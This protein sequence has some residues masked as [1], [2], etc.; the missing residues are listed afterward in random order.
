M[1]E[2]GSWSGSRKDFPAQ[3]LS[4]AE[5]IRGLWQSF[6]FGFEAVGAFVARTEKVIER[7]GYPDF[8]Q[9]NGSDNALLIKLSLDS[10]VV[11]DPEC[12]WRWRVHQSG[13]GWTGGP[14]DLAAALIAFMR[15]LDKDPTIRKFAAGHPAEWRALK[16]TLVENGW[17]TYLWRWRDVYKDRLS[18]IEWVKAAFAM[19]IHSSYYRRVASVFASRGEG[20]NAKA[21]WDP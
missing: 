1:N 20:A 2:E 14:R 13:Y 7:G 15:F 12:V 16:K 8:V 9:G 19:H 17:Q 11:L 18:G 6:E 10:N 3:V 4:G 5:F 21:L